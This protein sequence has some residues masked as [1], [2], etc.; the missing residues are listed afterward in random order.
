MNRGEGSTCTPIKVRVELRREQFTGELNKWMCTINGEQRVVTMRDV[1][2]YCNSLAE[3]LNTFKEEEI[4]SFV[5]TGN[6]EYNN[7]SNYNHPRY[8]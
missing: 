2:W 5:I 7:K 8:I 4:C 6:Y 1:E 3:A